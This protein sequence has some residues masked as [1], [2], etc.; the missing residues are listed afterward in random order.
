MKKV[1]KT[2]RTVCALLLAMTIILLEI[3]QLANS[4]GEV[5]NSKAAV[6]SHTKAT[7]ADVLSPNANNKKG[8]QGSELMKLCKA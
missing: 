5:L 2:C 8:V 7:S 6:V 4:F 3:P 1:K